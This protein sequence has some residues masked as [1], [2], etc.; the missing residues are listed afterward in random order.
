[1]W[2]PAPLAEICEVGSRTLQLLGRQ[3]VRD[4]SG[5]RREWRPH[6]LCEAVS[7]RESAATVKGAEKASRGVVDSKAGGDDSGA[8]K[9]SSAVYVMSKTSLMKTDDVAGHHDVGVIADATSVETEILTSLGEVGLG[10]L[11]EDLCHA[12]S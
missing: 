2:P 4:D 12:G 9:A 5:N 8:G 11:V 6:A 1:M 3:V 10:I 7:V